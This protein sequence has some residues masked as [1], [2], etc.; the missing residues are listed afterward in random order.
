MN[1]TNTPEV[2]P[3]WPGEVPNAELWQNAGPELERE[4]EDF[5]T[6]VG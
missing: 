2:I 1:S 5:T 4:C 6:Q 3:V